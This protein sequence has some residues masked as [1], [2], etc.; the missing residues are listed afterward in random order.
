[1]DYHIAWLVVKGL[2]PDGGCSY[3]CFYWIITW[4]GWFLRDYHLMAAAAVGVF[5]GLLPGMAGS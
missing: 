1:M 2:L 3:G 5:I 4:C